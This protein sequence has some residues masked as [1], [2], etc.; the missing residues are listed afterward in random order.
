[1]NSIG[2]LLKSYDSIGISLIDRTFL[3]GFSVPVAF[4]VLHRDHSSRKR[5]D[6]KC[7]CWPQT[8]ARFYLLSPHQKGHTAS[9]VMDNDFN[10][11]N[12][13][14]NT[15]SAPVSTTSDAHGARKKHKKINEKQL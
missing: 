9:Q 7:P 14:K 5:L 2:I 12:N 8:A 15:Y 11:N 3:E 4:R 13:Y 10:N 1:M 6:F